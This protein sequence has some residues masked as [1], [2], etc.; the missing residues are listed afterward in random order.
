MFAKTI[1]LIPKKLL[2]IFLVLEKFLF[3]QFGV[4]TSQYAA[5]VIETDG[6]L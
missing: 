5:E 2:G 3:K 6:G 1:F 4:G